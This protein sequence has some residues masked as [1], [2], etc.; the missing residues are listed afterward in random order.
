MKRF[1]NRQCQRKFKDCSL[2]FNNVQLLKELGSGTYGTVYNAQGTY[3]SKKYSFAVKEIR[4]VLLQNINDEYNYSI[5]MSNMK[6]GPRVFDGFYFLQ[7]SFI[8]KSKTKKQIPQGTYCTQYIFME[9][10]HENV[11]NLFLDKKLSPNDI[12]IILK[13]MIK[14]LF[15]KIFFS[16]VIC[17]DI[18]PSNFVFKIIDKQIDIRLIDFGEF[19]E[20][21]RLTENKRIAIFILLMVQ[22]AFNIKFLNPNIQ[23]ELKIFNTS[24]LFKNRLKYINLCFNELETNELMFRNY[25]HYIRK[26][27]SLQSLSD[28]Y[29]INTPKLLYK[30]FTDILK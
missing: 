5:Y 30:E 8:K 11:T 25:S 29:S 17:Y 9:K 3:K 27:N 18:K 4:N 26:T 24:E 6:L 19:C 15:N 12:K 22:L 16:N 23:K 21:N 10:Y 28:L 7:N 2:V 20:P 13:K 14:L 1:T